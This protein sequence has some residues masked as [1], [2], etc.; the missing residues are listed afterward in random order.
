[1]EEDI[2]LQFVFCY[3][4][5]KEFTLEINFL[6]VSEM[7]RCPQYIQFKQ[8]KPYYFTI[9]VMDGKTNKIILERTVHLQD[10][11]VSRFLSLFQ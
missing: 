8:E 1:M 5:M 11:K 4:V 2:N 9:T 3:F 7:G 6:K 10:F